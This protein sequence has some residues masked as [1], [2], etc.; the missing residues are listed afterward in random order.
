MDAEIFIGDLAAEKGVRV[1]R[2]LSDFADFGFRFEV[3]F[4]SFSSAR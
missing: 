1:E 4:I 3:V 2:K